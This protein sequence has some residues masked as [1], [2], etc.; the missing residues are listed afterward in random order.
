MGGR[1]GGQ[2]KKLPLNVKH[3]RHSEEETQK[4]E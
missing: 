2:E 1:E 3:T 4:E